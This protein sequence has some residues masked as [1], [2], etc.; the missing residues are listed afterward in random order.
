MSIKIHNRTLLS[1]LAIF[2][3][4]FFISSCARKIVF[5]PSVIVPAATGKVKVKKDAN[6]NYSIDLEV[7]NLADPNRLS[8]PRNIYVVWIMTKESGVKNIGQIKSSSGLF[9]DKLKASLRAVSP[10][11]PTRV[12]I[13]A[14]R[15][16]DV[17][18]PGTQEV[19]ST[20]SF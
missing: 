5:Q 4:V 20:R 19:L 1:V 9:S 12:F 15:N 18:Y 6:N 7:R 16:S 3:L 14:E 17:L 2:A 13:T 10:F 11:E 8:P